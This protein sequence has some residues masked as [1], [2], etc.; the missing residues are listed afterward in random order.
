[1]AGQIAGQAPSLWLLLLPHLLLAGGALAV[2]TAGAFWRTRPVRTLFVL[3]AASALLACGAALALPAL[4]GGAI[5]DASG[6]SAMLDSGPYARFYLVL[7]TGLTFTALLFLANYARQRGFEEDEPY[8]LVLL[9]ALGAMLLAQAVNW[10][11][12]F[13]GLET[14]SIPLYVII[15]ARRGDPKSGEAA[16][17]YFV[18]GAVASAV[19]LFGIA[20]LYAAT[21]TAEIAA[22]L[23]QPMSG[24]GL[25]GLGFLLAGLGFKLS[26][27]PFHLWTPD[28]YEGAPAPVTA[29]LS[30]ASKVGVF[31]GL[32]RLAV[33]GQGGM[34]DGLALVLWVLAAATMAGGNLGALAQGRVKR[35]L[36]Y[37]SVAQMGY[38]LMALLAVPAAGPGPIMFYSAVYA[39]MDLG[40]FGGLGLLSPREGDLNEFGDFSGLG[41]ARPFTAGIFA[42]SILALAGLPPTGGF[43]GKFL[44][45]AATLRAGYTILAALGVLTAVISM[46]YYLRLLAALYMRPAE[47][48]S[49]K[50]LPTTASGGVALVLVAFLILLLGIV[51]SPVISALAALH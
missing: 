26:L 18:M 37:S 8:A 24:T 45:F 19:L 32:L 31:A 12:F 23:S 50:G 49:A 28:V 29:F 15:A 14:L 47:E 38:L 2:F 43:V 4:T 17:K 27:V 9:A 21:G 13:L 7:L 6:L 34:W 33:Q 48:A 20:L 22:G 36:A 30:T 5:P 10:V 25:L 40:A 35:M 41:Y 42:F 39:L 44:L 51:P 11:I 3:S 1:M 16:V 46:G